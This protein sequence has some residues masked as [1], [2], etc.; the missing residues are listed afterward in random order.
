[1]NQFDEGHTRTPKQ[2]LIG[3]AGIWAA[4]VGFMLLT[5]HIPEIALVTI[6]AAVVATLM[7]FVSEVSVS[8]ESANW[9]TP[10]RSFL[11]GRG[12]DP[13]A[14]VLH[15]QLRD[16]DNRDLAASRRE[17]LAAALVEIIDDRVAASSGV[18]RSD[19]PDRFREIVGPDL[20]GLVASVE[21]GRPQLPP[22]SLP[23]ILSRIE[24]L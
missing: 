4:I 16:L 23:T 8:V 2:R 7:W 11:R 6:A 21:A 18:S 12:K 13:R 17:L 1:M 5:G 14:S 10:S 3:F 22:R 19:E 15:R 20:A 24:R 9:A